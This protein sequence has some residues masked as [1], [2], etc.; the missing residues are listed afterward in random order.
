MK[1][2]WF[3]PTSDYCK[4]NTIDG[5]ENSISGL[6]QD[7]TSGSSTSL[8]SVGV[9]SSYVSVHHSTGLY[10]P[11]EITLTINST[12]LTTPTAP[13]ATSFH[14]PII[15]TPNIDSHNPTEAD[16]SSTP[17]SE[18]TTASTTSLTTVTTILDSST[19]HWSAP[20]HETAT[21]EKPNTTEAEATTQHTANPITTPPTF[22]RPTTPLAQQTTNPTTKPTA[23]VSTS[24]PITVTLPQ[25]V[26]TPTTA[27]SSTPIEKLLHFNHCSKTSTIPRNSIYSVIWC[28]LTKNRF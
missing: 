23:Q 3:F 20:A 16:T 26:T 5:G 12:N 7:L 19:E 28:F 13:A 11:V 24:L 15:E 27:I 8:V 1:Y 10:N 9:G 17:G 6:D 2:C 25:V 22:Q 14:D 21:T 18:H 4:S